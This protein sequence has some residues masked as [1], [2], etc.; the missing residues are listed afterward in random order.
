MKTIF[1]GTPDFAV[2]SLRAL[3]AAGLSP[4]LVVTQP[5]KRRVRRGQ[6]SHSPVGEAALELGL[7]LLECERIAKNE[8]F[9]RVSEI[10]PEL[11]IVVAFGQILRKPVLQLARHGCINLHPS[12][13]PQYRGAAPIQ[14]AVMDGVRESGISVIQLVRALDAGPILKQVPFALGENESAAEALERAADAGAALIVEVVQAIAAGRGPV[15]QAQDDALANYAHM[16]TKEDGAIDFAA[17]VAQVHNLIRGV[18]P[19]PGAFTHHHGGLL[20][21]HQA[22]VLSN[23]RP[24]AAAGTIVGLGK[25][26][27]DVAC[28]DGV[29]RI[30]E[31][32]AENRPR[33]L[34]ADFLN[35]A[36]IALGDRLA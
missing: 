4:A 35:G 2:P 27:M 1:L 21:V 15:P 17:P 11:M 14:R 29:L 16:L 22:R 18:T 7:E 32:Q 6:L 24:A 30:L 36:K 33:R 8:A 34:V 13:L 10:A 23:S 3:V 28:G 5:S 19:W 26:G 9:E 12:M 31:V 20:K 25:D